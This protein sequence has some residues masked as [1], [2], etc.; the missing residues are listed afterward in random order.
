ML[1]FLEFI[2]PSFQSDIRIETT[3]VFNLKTQ[4]FRVV[5]EFGLS[6]F[7]WD[8]EHAGSSRLPSGPAYSTNTVK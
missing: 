3:I 6:R 2:V 7:I 5:E 8:E 4:L 1:F